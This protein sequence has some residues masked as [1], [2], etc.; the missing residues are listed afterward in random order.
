MNRVLGFA[1]VLIFFFY[2]STGASGDFRIGPFYAEKFPVLDV[3]VE[4]ASAINAQNLTLI[5][6]GQ[7]TVAAS[8]V[9]PFKDTGRGMAVVLALDVSGTMAGQPINDMKRALSAFLNQA[10]AQDRVAIVTFADDVR[11]DA[12]F[13]SSPEQLK[14]AV[15]GLAARGKITEL[16]KGLRQ[17]LALFD[18]TS[19]PERK[20]LIV[21]SDGWDEG[22]AYKLED[23]IEEAQRRNVPVDAVGLTKVDPKYLSNLNRLADKTGGTYQR[24]GDS[25][26]LEGIFRQGIEQLQSTPVATFTASKLQADGQEH[27]LGVRVDANGRLATAETR[28]ILNKATAASVAPVAIPQPSG[29]T[30]GVKGLISRLPK[31]VWAVAVGGLIAI[32]LLVVWL[33]RRS[34]SQA[35]SAG[36]TVN[37]DSKSALPPNSARS[38]DGLE[39]AEIHPVPSPAIYD[40][41]TIPDMGKA[42]PLV[43]PYDLPP[44][45]EPLFDSPDKTAFEGEF[46]EF[47]TQRFVGE[48]DGVRKPENQK[49][50][51]TQVDS[52]PSTANSPSDTAAKTRARRK[53]QIRVEFALPS[54]GKPCATLMAEEGKF[55]GTAF[56]IETSPFWIGS[57]DASQLF[58]EGDTFLSGFHACIEFKEGSLLLHDNH[59]TNGTFLNE[60]PVK[61]MPRALGYGDRIK[62]GRSVFVV[63]RI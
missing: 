36:I 59:S 19:L 43:S 4:S 28:L 35:H 62:V 21:I 34:A 10:G 15:N 46:S 13:G 27:R 45:T 63:M 25:E 17:A 31:W 2:Q 60:Q 20:R 1:Y 22:V 52:S 58:V 48:V 5:E 3:V 6:D 37:S 16:Y 39:Q 8:S 11:V 33:K 61:D 53:T 18:D 41:P 47:R 49:L 56:P 40:G 57:E 50:E 7:A 51:G 42:G 29:V 14:A 24:A 55:T 23:V 26:K 32:I 9:R 44:L 38:R 12:K 30:G 54:P